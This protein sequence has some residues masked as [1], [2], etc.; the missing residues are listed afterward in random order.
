MLRSDTQETRAS[1]EPYQRPMRWY[2]KPAWAQPCR[3]HVTA[4]EADSERTPA[5][6]ADREHASAHDAHDAYAY[7]ISYTHD[8]RYYFN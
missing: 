6:K 3:S 5:H 2:R 4:H 7:Y 8:A 1:A